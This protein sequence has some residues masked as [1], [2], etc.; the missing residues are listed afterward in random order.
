M[1][2]SSVSSGIFS[3]FESRPVVDS[4]AGTAM[5]QQPSVAMIQSR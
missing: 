1:K 3:G 4:V 5:S 2:S